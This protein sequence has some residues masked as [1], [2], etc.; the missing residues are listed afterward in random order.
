MSMLLG[1]TTEDSPVVL[2][3]QGRYFVPALVLFFLLMRNRSVSIKA[4]FERYIYAAFAIFETYAVWE[5][6]RGAFE[7]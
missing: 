4:G 2:G 7:R 6:F 1:W 3:M 5:L